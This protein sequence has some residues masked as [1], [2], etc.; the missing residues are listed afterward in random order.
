MNKA[1]GR[2]AKG[3]FRMDGVSWDTQKPLT[4][5]DAANWL[6]SQQE[7]T[8]AASARKRMEDRMYRE[9]SYANDSHA[10][11]SKSGTRVCANGGSK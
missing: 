10:E 3:N 4:P 11:D 6:E 2:I 1:Y 7:V 5:Q 8:G 9:G